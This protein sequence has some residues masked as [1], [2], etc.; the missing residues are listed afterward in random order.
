M[1]SK[2]NSL[3]EL[4]AEKARL[5]AQIQLAHDELTISTRRTRAVFKNFLEDKLNIP[6]QLFRLFQ[7]GGNGSRQ[8][9][10]IG[11]IGQVAGLS[12]WWSGLLATI[13]PIVF[14]FVRG[15]ISQRKERKQEAET[16]AQK[17]EKP[18]TKTKRRNP[19]KRKK[20]T[21]ADV[22]GAS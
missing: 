19:F 17:T 18:K 3:D 7:G 5:K 21:P 13:V 9:S 1:L 8:G 20:A 4:L 16:E 22:A 14:N 11:A 12:A 15:K 2:I 6:E 10:V